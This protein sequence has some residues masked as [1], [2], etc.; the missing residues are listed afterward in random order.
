MD[1]KKNTN[2]L[3]RKRLEF[4]DWM[5]N[6]VRTIHYADNEKMLLAYERIV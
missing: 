5:L 2:E 3:I 1:N 4:N 6:K